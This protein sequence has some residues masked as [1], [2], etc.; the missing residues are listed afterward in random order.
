MAKINELLKKILSSRYGRDVR[1]AIH[2]SIE[3]MNTESETAY[4]AAITAK[5]SAQASANSAA[6]SATNAANSAKSAA[7]SA[8]EAKETIERLAVVQIS[9]DDFFSSI[10][11]GITISDFRAY[12]YGKIIN[13]QRCM[14]GGTIIKDVN[15]AQ[16]NTK[17]SP[18]SELPIRIPVEANGTSAR[19]DKFFIK[20]GG[21]LSGVS[22]NIS[23]ACLFNITYIT[24]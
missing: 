11:S 1:S 24:N 15:F 20:T 2:D 6:T 10:N 16:I 12:K 8:T 13:I 14:I 5:D 3:A 17:Y 19:A 9:K 23:S 22:E 18:I 21:I 7:D 4:D